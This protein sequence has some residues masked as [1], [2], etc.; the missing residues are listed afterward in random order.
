V[1]NQDIKKQKGTDKSQNPEEVPLRYRWWH[2]GK[3]MP[4]CPGN[5]GI[6]DALP[7]GGLGIKK[8]MFG[9]K[10]GQILVSRISY[11]FR[12]TWA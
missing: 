5:T 11:I 12:G 10:D 8:N 4:E 6:L 7:S 3:A 1:H 9:K 2:C